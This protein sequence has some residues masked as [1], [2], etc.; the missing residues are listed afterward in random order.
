MRLY[1]FVAVRSG[2]LA[3]RQSLADRTMRLH[4]AIVDRRCQ[5][6]N[7]ILKEYQNY[8]ILVITT[9]SIWMWLPYQQNSLVH[10]KIDSEARQ[11]VFEREHWCEPRILNGISHIA[12]SLYLTVSG[13]ASG[14]TFPQT[15][16]Q[17][18]YNK[19]IK[20]LSRWRVSWMYS[21]HSSSTKKLA[22]IEF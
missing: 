9:E 7:A 2:T 19:I 20:Y 6:N 13:F 22:H 15:P 8:T 4:G 21:G 1:T 11:T 12:V 17:Y 5:F 3:G 18:Y 10:I 16:Y 14:R